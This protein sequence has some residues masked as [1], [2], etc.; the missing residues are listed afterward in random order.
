MKFQQNDI[1]T[2]RLA[3]VAITPESLWSERSGDG[4]LG[5]INNAHVPLEWP[6]EQ[7][8]L[9]VFELLIKR[10]GDD[11]TEL[12]WH[13]YVALRHRDRSRTLIGT[14]GGFRTA[15]RPEKVEVGYSVLK[16]FQG[17][18]YAT[19]GTKAL[20]DWALARSSLKMISAQTFPSLPKS[21]RVMEKCGMKYVGAGDEEGSVR[22]QWQRFD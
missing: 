15:Q 10:F 5:T 9:H 2:S 21:I 12:G 3:L 17:K 11:P 22:Y 7:W 6:P 13:R 16:D 4:L 1:I 19:E 14:L 8:E 20:I 18:G